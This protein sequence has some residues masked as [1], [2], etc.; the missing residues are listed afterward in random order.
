MTS[1]HEVQSFSPQSPIQR[2]PGP[3]TA[4]NTQGLLSLPDEI[5]LEIFNSLPGLP[6]PSARK[7]EEIQAHGHRRP[8]LEALSQT[9]RALRRVSLPFLWERIEVFSGMQTAKGPLPPVMEYRGL[10]S[11]GRLHARE[12][13]RQLEVVTIRE[14]A[15]ADFVRII[16][17]CIPEDSIET[18][19]RELARC[20]TLMPNLHTIQICFMSSHTFFM[21][22]R[23][24]INT[25]FKPYTYPQIKIACVHSQASGLLAQCPNMK[26][27][28]PMKS[29]W[30]MISL[31][32][33]DCLKSILENSP[34]VETL[35]LL[36]VRVPRI[37]GSDLF[38]QFISI[39]SRF[40]NLRDI[41]FGLDAFP[42]KSDMKLLWKI[43]NLHVIRIT[44]GKIYQLTEQEVEEWTEEMRIAIHEDP[45]FA[46]GKD[47]E[48][49][50]ST[51]SDQF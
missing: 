25:V 37:I 3:F 51:M 15:F 34:A 38:E 47:K 23:S 11:R 39:A 6:I 49:I 14:P 45:D 40:R 48:L 20:M 44:F 12:L 21:K 29:A 10:L 24:M 5:L 50:V 1:T 43:P 13:L 32:S 8:T 16:D 28:H 42:T 41:H 9:C 31:N 17:V 33:V 46:V 35:G 27:F 22:K 19:L 4:C 18:V 26:A 30:R 36:P 2:M 7:K